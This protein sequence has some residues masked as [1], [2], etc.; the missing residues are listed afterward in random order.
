MSIIK[1]LKRWDTYL[2]DG[3]SFVSERVPYQTEVAVMLLIGFE[4][5]KLKD[6]EQGVNIEE[7]LMLWADMI[8]AKNSTQQRKGQRTIKGKK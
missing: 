6:G 2:V 4:P 3:E 8:R 7:Q 1:R 5:A